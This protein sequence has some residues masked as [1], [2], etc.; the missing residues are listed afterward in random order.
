MVKDNVLSKIRS[1]IISN[2]AKLDSYNM[3]IGELTYNHKCH[4]NSVQKVKEDKA[5]SVVACVA[6]NKN[7][8]D[9]IIVHFI[10]KLKGKNEIYQDN[11]W[12]YLYNEYDYYIIK[13]L[14]REEEHNI[15]IYFSELRKFLIEG[16]SNG[17]E[18]FLLKNEIKNE[19]LI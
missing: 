8:S 10:N 11:T 9:E 19:N 1:Y 4:L 17:L 16:N 18:R 7:N 2:Y 12:G 5:K 15:G 6:I 14:S 13:E 3:R